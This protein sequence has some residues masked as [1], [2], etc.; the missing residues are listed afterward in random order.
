MEETFQEAKKKTGRK[1][2]EKATTSPDSIGKQAANLQ[3]Q[4]AHTALAKFWA[5]HSLGA[6]QPICMRMFEI[7]CALSNKVL[8]GAG[9]AAMMARDIDKLRNLALGA[10]TTRVVE[11]FEREPAHQGIVDN[12]DAFVRY[13][14]IHGGAVKMKDILVAK[15]M[16]KPTNADTLMDGMI[17]KTIKK[18]IVMAL[19]PD[20]SAIEDQQGEYY[21]TSLTRGS[22]AKDLTSTAISMG[23][24]CSNDMMGRALA[25]LSDSSVAMSKC[26]KYENTQEKQHVLHIK[27]ELVNSTK[28]L[29]D[30]EMTILH[31]MRRVTSSTVHGCTTFAEDFDEKHH[32]LSRHIRRGL[33]ETYTHSDTQC[34]AAM[35]ELSDEMDSNQMHT[36][37][38]WL[39][40]MRTAAGEHL[41]EES[42]DPAT[43]FYKIMRVEEEPEPTS[44][45]CIP[46]GKYPGG[47]KVPCL[48]PGGLRVNIEALATF[49]TNTDEQVTEAEFMFADLVMAVS[50]EAAVGDTIFYALSDVIDENTSAAVTHTVREWTGGSV[51]VPNPRRRE[52]S[53]VLDHTKLLANDAIIDESLNTIT[54]NNDSRLWDR[55][56]DAACIANTTLCFDEAAANFAAR[57]L[58]Q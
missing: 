9:Q 8:V 50:G 49:D 26:I 58:A 25:K 2:I 17:I 37:M 55:I 22:V 57:F 23:L 18:N 10:M 45:P 35:K 44:T 46:T 48:Y 43:R 29:T 41:I 27:K 28:V 52:K 40:R 6:L 13:Y 11:T 39:K 51:T 15:N 34:D 33:I 47:H 19:G 4:Y 5:C 36:A 32:L 30:S 14:Q 38:F 21:V 3:F 31:W 24:D 1:K 12:Y 42:T 54:L 53:A 7:F 16:A 56:R 20:A